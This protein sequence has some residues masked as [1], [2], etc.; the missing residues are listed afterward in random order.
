MLLCGV[1]RVF[2]EIRGHGFDDIAE[3]DVRLKVNPSLKLNGGSGDCRCKGKSKM[4]LCGVIR[5]LREIRG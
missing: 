4:L 2:R 1:I 5:V 3:E